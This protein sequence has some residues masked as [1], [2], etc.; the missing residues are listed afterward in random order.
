MN[1]K[2][3]VF[4][5]LLT[6]LIMGQQ[7]TG[8]CSQAP[9]PTVEQIDLNLP[10]EIRNC[11]SA[12]RSPGPKATRRQTAAYIVKLYD[13]WEECHGDLKEVDKLYSKWKIEVKKLKGA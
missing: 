12:P 3:V 10:D 7:A 8:G 2:P 1:F 5:A 11:K 4:V 9:L 13:A 6:P